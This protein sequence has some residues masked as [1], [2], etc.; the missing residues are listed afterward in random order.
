MNYT[1]KVIEAAFAPGPMEIIFVIIIFFIPALLP[2]LIAQ[3]KGRNFHAWYVYGFFLF[4]IALIHSILIK[5]SHNAVGM[6]K[7]PY[8]AETIKSEAVVCKHCGSML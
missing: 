1:P 5:P 3:N 7:C 4:I 6:K 8:C 2:A